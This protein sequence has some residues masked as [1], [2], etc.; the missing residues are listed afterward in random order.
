MQYS[1]YL[2][3]CS[4]IEFEYYKQEIKTLYYE[5]ISKELLLQHK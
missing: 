2:Y 3:L 1:F 4:G 5:D